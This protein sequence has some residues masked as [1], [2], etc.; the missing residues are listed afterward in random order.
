MLFAVFLHKFHIWEN[1]YHLDMGQNV[2]SNKIAGFF[3]Q[4]YIQNKS[5]KQPGFLYGDTNSHKLKVGK[6]IFG[7]S[8]SK[9]VRPVWS[10]DSKIDRF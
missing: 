2:L 5:V 9:R 8:S 1:F 7:R 4:P 3:D 6:N 10:R